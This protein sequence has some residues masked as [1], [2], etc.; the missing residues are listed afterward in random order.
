MAVI[1]VA[2]DKVPKKVEKRWIPSTEYTKDQL[3]KL[4][5][6]SDAKLDWLHEERQKGSIIAMPRLRRIGIPLID[7]KTGEYQKT[8]YG[9]V[10]DKLYHISWWDSKPDEYEILTEV[11][12]DLIN[13]KMLEN[14]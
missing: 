11:Y 13:D 1:K 5:D 9:T 2:L 3:L 6:E 14:Y 10:N 4:M 12:W 7:T 8:R